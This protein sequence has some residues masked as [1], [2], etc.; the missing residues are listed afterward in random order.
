MPGELCFVSLET[1]LVS[2]EACLLSGEPSTLLH[3]FEALRGVLIA[4]RVL[5]CFFRDVSAFFGCVWLLR[6]I[7]CFLEA[8]QGVV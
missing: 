6:R 7:F 4:R 1:C 8:E 2:S 3:E 5:P